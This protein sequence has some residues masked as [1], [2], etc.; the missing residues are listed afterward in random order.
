[1]DECISFVLN[2]KKISSDSEYIYYNL[3]KRYQNAKSTN[4]AIPLPQEKK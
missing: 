4:V 3:K 2:E 1:M